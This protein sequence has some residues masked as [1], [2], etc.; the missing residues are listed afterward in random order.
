MSI[1]AHQSVGEEIANAISHGI[2]L[3]LG[4]T[5][6]VLL[7]VFSSTTGSAWHIVSFVIFGSGLIILYLFSTLLHSF[8]KTKAHDTFQVLDQA[9]IYFVIAATYTP[10]TLVALNGSLGWTL[11][12]IEW[13]LAVLG[14]V[15]KASNPERFVRNDVVVTTTTYAIMGWL[16]LVGMKPLYAA[17]GFGGVALLVAG[18]LA[19]TLGIIFFTM[20]KM[21]YH[22]LVWH[23]FVLAGSVFHFFAVIKYVL[24]I[25]V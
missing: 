11:F 6:L 12:G 18:G 15:L 13:G 10:F 14:T 4:I 5:A 25:T 21:K 2:G 1:V 22:H 3:L 9:G 7:A 16:I 19:Y 24:P 23:L 8:A 20:K 17:V